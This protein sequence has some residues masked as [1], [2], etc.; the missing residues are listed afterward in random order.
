[1]FK[2]I[3]NLFASTTTKPTTRKATLGFESMETRDAPAVL[4]TGS[5]RSFDPQ[6]EPPHTQIVQVGTVRG[7]VISGG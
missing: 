7:I 4:Y 3:T 1:M 5:I 6:P 2:A